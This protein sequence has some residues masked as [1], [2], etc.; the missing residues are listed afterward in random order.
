MRNEILEELYKNKGG[1]IS[2]ETLATN[3]GISRA[4]VWKHINILKRD[5]YSIGT[6]P[7]RGYKL[8]EM[9]DKL[10]PGEIENSIHNNIIGKQIIYFDSIDS[11][12]NYA[13]KKA[14]QLRDGTV[15][16][17]E[18]QIS[19]R[20]RRG[21]EWISPK[22][23]GIW[24]SLILKPDIPPREG[25]KMTQIAA[26]AVCESIRKLTGLDALIKWPND[27]VLNGK[28]ICG[29]L[30]EMAGELNEISYV[31]IGIGINANI[32]HFPEGIGSK[33]TSL[34]IEGGKK[35]DR[36]KLLVDILGN[37]EIIYNNYILHLNLNDILPM[38][39]TYS[40]VLGKNIRI[41]QDKSEKMGR[42][43]DINDDGL[44]LVEMEDGNRELISSGEISIRGER[45]YI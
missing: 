9:K 41:I 25:I 32:E 14:G 37:F 31:V 17:A 38:I 28:K 36:K 7:G 13:K 8:L 5:G 2:G 40:A 15:V 19:G 42:A 34:F 29:I 12:N 21:K 6:A 35:V 26:V 43:V 10:L 11:T 30:T 16:L 18:E 23:T 3:L 45:G 22:G 39:K 4:A 24:M 44:L 1:Y 20:G 27:I 33:A